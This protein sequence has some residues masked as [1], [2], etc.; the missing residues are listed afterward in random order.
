VIADAPAPPTAR[1]SIEASV[2]LVERGSFEPRVEALF[3]TE[4]LARD[5]VA[6]RVRSA[7]A[8]DRT[9]G[10]YTSDMVGYYEEYWTVT[11]VTLHT[12]IPP[13]PDA[14]SMYEDVP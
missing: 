6:L 9:I 14:L 2:W 5:Y 11:P 7:I 13:V 8:Y 4:T 10:V 1:V 12:V 3:L